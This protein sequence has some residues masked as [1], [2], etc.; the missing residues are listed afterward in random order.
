MGGKENLDSFQE[1][2]FDFEKESLSKILPKLHINMNQL[3]K[4]WNN[5]MQ[6]ILFLDSN[7][8]NFKNIMN[9]E[10]IIKDRL[11]N[12]QMLIFLFSKKYSFINFEVIRKNGILHY[13]FI[14]TILGE[15]IN[16]ISKLFNDLKNYLKENNF[17]I[18]NRELINMNI[19]ALKRQS[20]KD[21]QK[22]SL[23]EATSMIKNQ[24]R[25][26]IINTTANN[27]ENEN[28]DTENIQSFG[29][30]ETTPQ[31]N[32]ILKNNTENNFINSITTPTKEN[33]FSFR[34]IDNQNNN[35]KI[36]NNNNSN[37]KKNPENIINHEI[38]SQNFDLIN[39]VGTK[40]NLNL[41]NNK[42]QIQNYTNEFS[43]LQK[44]NNKRRFSNLI[45][46][47]ENINIPINAST[48]DTMMAISIDEK[49]EILITSDSRG[50]LNFFTFIKLIF[51]SLLLLC[52]FI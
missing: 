39:D 46:E 10:Y 45:L 43:I 15:T 7:K 22:K 6:D 1:Y 29:D 41:I 18:Q 5:Y 14:K 23:K 9:I 13:E 21:Q 35:Y 17:K 40:I 3:K 32:H 26:D 25:N 4:N 49:K 37:I 52:F 11:Y 20:I 51:L 42:L 33:N 50:N 47:K 31:K 28:L 8:N 12:F 48:K 24:S 36:N 2:L 34:S 38:D 16:L 44:E 27:N 19:L 30:I